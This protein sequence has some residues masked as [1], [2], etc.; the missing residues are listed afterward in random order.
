MSKR[1]QVSGGECRDGESSSFRF[2]VPSSDGDR[3]IP[4]FA[5]RRSMFG[6][7]RWKLAVGYWVLD[8]AAVSASLLLATAA[9]AQFDASPF[10]VSATRGSAPAGAVVDV[11]FTI[12]AGHRIYADSLSVTGLEGTVLAPV[13]IPAPVSKPDPQTGEIHPFHAA[14]FT[15]RYSIVSAPAAGPALSVSLQGCDA[16]QCFF[17]ETR[18]LR[19]GA[20]APATAPAPAVAAAATGSGPIP[21]DFRIARRTAGYQAE[22]PFLDFLAGRGAGNVLMNRGWFVALLLILGGGLLLNFTPCVLP[23]IP[24][25]LAIIGAGAQAQSRGRGFLLGGIYGLGMALAYGVLGVVVVLT[26]APFGA[27][28]ASPWFNAGIAALFV[29]LSLAMFGVFNI[30]FSAIQG[31]MGSPGASRNR[32]F[33]AFSLGVVAALLAGACVAPILI[34]V[35][36]LAASMYQQGHTAGLLLPFLLG[37]GMALPWPFAGAGLAFLPKPGGWMDKVKYG[38]GIFILAMAAYYG[39][40]AW[41]GFRATGAAPVT[42]TASSNGTA[43]IALGP[44]STAA[45]WQKVFDDARAA[46]KPVLIDFWATWCKNCHAM[47]ASTFRKPAVTDALRSFVFVKYQAEKPGETPAK[48]ILA[49]FGVMGLPT[50]VVLEPAA[51]P[52]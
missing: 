5:V 10:G 49:A 12:P 20:G 21:A 48:E 30:D 44:T 23:M 13:S 3:R 51:P 41:S 50:Y 38:F 37:I 8:V 14:T 17:P 2:H 4:A 52:P 18:E 16:T 19:P 6:V 9:S 33:A 46:G 27:L 36:V 40:L 25:N 43:G 34:G 39:H 1:C 47:E 22:S 29:G 31:R 42:A 15:A 45:D 35:L 24:I 7:P 26:G 32:F 28:N 11:A